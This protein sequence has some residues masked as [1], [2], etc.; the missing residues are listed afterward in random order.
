VRTELLQHE[1]S[2]KAWAATRSTSKVSALKKHQPRQ[3]ARTIL[4][5]AEVL[6]LKANPDRAA[7]GTSSKPS[8]TRAAARWRPCWSSAAR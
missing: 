8:S 3:A 4:L 6:D 5:Q 7:E 1:V 2:S